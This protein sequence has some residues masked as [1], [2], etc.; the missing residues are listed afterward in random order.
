MKSER[1]LHVTGIE[2]DAGAAAEAASALDAVHCGDVMQLL[3]AMPERSFDA[4][5][6]ADVLEHVAQPEVLLAHVARILDPHGHVILSVPNVRHWSVLREI[7]EGDFQYREAGILDR[8]HL[9]FYTRKSLLRLLAQCGLAPVSLA[10]SAWH[11]EC[12][13][14][15]IVAALAAAGLDVSTLAEESGVHQFLV[16]AAPI[17]AAAPERDQL[18]VVTACAPFAASVNHAVAATTRPFVAI[19]APGVALTDEQ[20]ARLVRHLR[21]DARIGAVAP[22]TDDADCGDPVSA[23]IVER[24]PGMVEDTPLV[25]SFCCVVRRDALN[26]AGPI[27]DLGS[28]GEAEMRDCCMRLRRLGYRIVTARDVFV[29]RAASA[30]AHSPGAA[31]LAARWRDDPIL[32]GIAAQRA[33]DLVRARALFEASWQ[34]YAACVDGHFHLAALSLEHGEMAAALEHVDRYLARHPRSREALLIRASALLGLA[35]QA[36]VGE[37]LQLLERECYLPASLAGEIEL[38]RSA[39]VPATP[40]T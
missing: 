5:I 29:P 24:F 33:H 6:L 18:A 28:G 23:A 35:R 9:R 4:V 2:M 34:S 39:L 3:P 7:L 15:P 20:W 13:P 10:G 36:E 38:I 19:V 40:A 12:A 31:Q 1:A 32:A 37:V 26:A 25:A 30:G 8:G 21:R 14:D 11:R 17:E 16:V 27:T 22:S